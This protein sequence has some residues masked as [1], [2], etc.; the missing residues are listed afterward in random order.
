MT[1]PDKP[2]P[3]TTELTPPT[4]APVLQEKTGRKPGTFVPGD[5]RINRRGRPKSFAQLRETVLRFL[6]EQD[7][8]ASCTRL[9]TILRQLAADDPKTLLEYG[10]GRVPQ[11]VEGEITGETKIIHVGVDL[12]KI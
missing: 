7:D 3:T 6:A 10:F 8:A 12:S 4:P 2:T 1:M 9:E 5:K 11:K